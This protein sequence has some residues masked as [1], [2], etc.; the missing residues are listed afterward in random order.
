MEIRLLKGLLDANDTMATRN[1]RAFEDAG[2]FAL[3]VLAGPGAGK[4]TTILATIAALR[5]RYRI[6]VIEGDVASRLDADK[7]KAQGVPAVQVNTGGACH[8]DASM[9]R[10][11]VEALDLAVLDLVIIENVGNLV[12]PTEFDL[13]QHARVVILSVPEGHDKPRKYPGVFSIADAVLLNKYDTLPVFDFDEA[14]FR[15]AMSR[16]NGRAPIFP[17]SATNGD[18]VA[19]W[20]AWL[21]A[22]IESARAAA[23][24]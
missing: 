4:T 15:E 3:D 14:Q 12:C 2:V 7:V 9:V 5:G 10:R 13:G 1:R 23:P 18:G 19:E 16:M 17:M 24:A 11:A 22:R 20:A 6:A 21:V 8:L